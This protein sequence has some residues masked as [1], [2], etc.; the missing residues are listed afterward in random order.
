MSKTKNIERTRFLIS[1]SFSSLFVII[2]WLI[3]IFETSLH[4]DF[5]RAGVFPHSIRH[6]SGILTAPLIHG[7]FEHL[8]S[9]T[10][11]LLILLTTV[12]FFFPKKGLAVFLLSWLG[13]GIIT[14][15]IGRPAYH[16]GASGIIY[17]LAAFLF[18]GGV[19]SK[20]TKYIAVALIVV[21]LYGSMIWGIFPS[22]NKTISWEGHL[23][24]FITG[25]ILA[26]LWHPKKID[27]NYYVKQKIF[28][29]PH[30]N[31]EYFSTTNKKS[32]IIVE[33][34]T[35]TNH[36]KKYIYYEKNIF[37]SD[38]TNFWFWHKSST[39]IFY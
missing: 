4:L 25:T 30:Y 32:E 35:I 2:L 33:F 5:S 3:K 31:F 19:L 21:F 12:L 10:F 36:Q 16:I 15:F 34:E 18:F 37:N 20:E 39:T 9:N 38:V 8:F 14:W 27:F 23:G 11:P 7:N 26:L 1:L 24:G 6:I 13:A 17:G 29:F 22:Q 28:I